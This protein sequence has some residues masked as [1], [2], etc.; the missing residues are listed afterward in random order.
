MHRGNY[1]ES[2]RYNEYSTLNVLIEGTDE[3]ESDE[4][5][6]QSNDQEDEEEKVELGKRGREVQ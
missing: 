3:S 5:V 1:H 4:E 6:E 2:R